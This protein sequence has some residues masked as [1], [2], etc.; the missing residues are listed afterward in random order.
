M[1][2][3][4]TNGELT[5]M[6]ENLDTRSDERHAEILT[7]LGEL[8]KDG[9]ATLEQAQK[10]NGRVNKHDFIFKLM[11]GAVGALISALVIGAPLAWSALKL[12][13]DLISK[14]N[15]DMAANSAVEKL[16]DKWNFIK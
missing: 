3:A 10:T 8:K 1:A 6:I 5:I 14:K 15:A 16:E 2:K 4:L 11:W 7:V 9:K 13:I 12:Q